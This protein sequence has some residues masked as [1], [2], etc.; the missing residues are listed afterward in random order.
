MNY[1]YTK[2]IM[3]AV[4]VEGVIGFPQKKKIMGNKHSKGITITCRVCR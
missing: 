4:Y 3:D 2:T 1:W